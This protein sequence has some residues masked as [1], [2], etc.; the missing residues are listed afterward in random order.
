MRKILFLDCQILIFFYFLLSEIFTFLMK[1]FLILFFSRMTLI[2][3]RIKR[4]AQLTSSVKQVTLEEM[5]QKSISEIL[6]LR[7]SRIK[8][9][10]LELS[11]SQKK[12]NSLFDQ[13]NGSI[14]SRQISRIQ[15]VTQFHLLRQIQN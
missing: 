2:R 3:C 15:E 12:I 4:L 1:S 5:F 7:L 9:R 8:L 14:S 6:C 13:D 11:I 10:V